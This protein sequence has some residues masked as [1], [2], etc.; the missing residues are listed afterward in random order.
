MVKKRFSVNLD[1]KNSSSNRPIEV[2]EGDNG[3]EIGVALTDGGAPVDL[4]GCRVLAVFSKSDG[5]TAQQDNDGHGVVMEE[6]KEGRFTIA[7]YTGSFSPGL[8]ECE[9][10]VLS[11]EAFA[12][13]VTS[14]K[15]NFSCRRSIM[16]RDTVQAID[17]YPILTE[18]IG[19]VTETENS[20]SDIAER[21]DARASAENERLAAE[22][23]RRADEE[24]RRTLAE[25]WAAASAAAA[26][27]PPGSAATAAVEMGERG[28]TFT[29]GVPRGEAGAPGDNARP[30][31]AQHAENG[32]DALLPSMI[33]AAPAQRCY[34]GEE[35]LDLNDFTEPGAYAFRSPERAAMQNVPGS[36]LSLASPAMLF[37]GVS[38]GDG[39]EEAGGKCVQQYFTWMESGV[40]WTRCIFSGGSGETPFAPQGWKRYGF[41]PETAAAVLYADCW[42][43]GPPAQQTLNI[44][45]IT[46]D[47]Q[48]VHVVFDLAGNASQEQTEAAVAGILRATGQ[49]EGA[50]TVT[51]FGEVPKIDIPVNVLLMR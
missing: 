39:A 48:N 9:I 37:V 17:E 28:V 36:S 44:G 7:L 15:F 20:L 26:T 12:T 25:K 29:F 24:Q 41:A 5:R 3:N 43:G 49:G 40:L 13:L 34:G 21:E 4:T 35:P 2:V 30:H 45:G 18:L 51:A 42:A 8:V 31:A 23:A 38:G 1:V 19:R 22:E 16:N 33:G 32:S 27:L 6:E 11:G 47:G 14:A 46:A 10:Q 50:L